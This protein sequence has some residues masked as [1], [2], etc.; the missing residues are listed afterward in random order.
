M[1][2]IAPPLLLHVNEI[3][4]LHFDDWNRDT[5]AVITRQTRSSSTLRDLQ[6]SNLDRQLY[7]PVFGATSSQKTIE[8]PGTENAISFHVTLQEA[9]GTDTVISLFLVLRHLKKREPGTENSISL[10]VTL[11]EV[12][13][14]FARPIA[15]SNWEKT[16]VELRRL[17]KFSHPTKFEVEMDRLATSK[18]AASG[19]V[20]PT[21]TYQ[22]ALEG[23][24]PSSMDLSHALKSYL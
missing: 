12:C 1:D 3:W 9:S 16:L 2:F 22:D 20:T 19:D 4:A 23:Q 15:I 8:K 10:H 21:A 6:I 11:W 24:I 17:W 18:E 5:L 7:N 14:T 13:G